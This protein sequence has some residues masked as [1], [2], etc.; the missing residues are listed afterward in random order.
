MI[1]K[2]FLPPPPLPVLLDRAQHKSDALAAVN[3]GNT[4]NVCV[5]AQIKASAAGGR[6]DGRHTVDRP[7]IRYSKITFSRVTAA[8][9]T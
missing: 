6:A 8:S 1:H 4:N 3:T 7:C 2:G 5:H 9:K